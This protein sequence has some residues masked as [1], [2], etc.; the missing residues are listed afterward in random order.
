MIAE[1]AQISE[2][3][4]SASATHIALVALTEGSAENAAPPQ[5]VAWKILV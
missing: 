1:M 3:N 2:V 5:N 4:H